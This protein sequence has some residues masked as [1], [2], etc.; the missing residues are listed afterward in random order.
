MSSRSLVR[1]ASL[2]LITRH[3]LIRQPSL[4]Q[5]RQPGMTKRALMAPSSMQGNRSTEH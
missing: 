4:A 2:R 3:T 1:H 5:Q